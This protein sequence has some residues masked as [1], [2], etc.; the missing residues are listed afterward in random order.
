MSKSKKYFFKWLANHPGFFERPT[1]SIWDTEMTNPVF[2]KAISK[3]KQAQACFSYLES[4][5]AFT[6]CHCY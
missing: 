6:I 2:Q 1:S 3:S 5:I 4:K